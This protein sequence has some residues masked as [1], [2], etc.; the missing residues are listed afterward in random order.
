MINVSARFDV[1]AA[2]NLLWPA[3]VKFENRAG[4][5]R[6]VAKPPAQSFAYF[7]RLAGPQ[8]VFIY[9]RNA[10]VLPSPIPGAGEK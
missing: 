10:A 5:W 9:H 2:G 6:C 1:S 3:A 7:L 4:H 8:S